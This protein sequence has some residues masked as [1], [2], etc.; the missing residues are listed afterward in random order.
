VPGDASSSARGQVGLD[1]LNFFLANA[2]TGFGAFIAVYLTSHKWTQ[3]EIGLV[4]SLGTAIAVIS[5]VPAG[6]LV[7]AL[8]KKR[9][10]AA[11]GILGIMAAAL[12]L[13]LLPAQLP[14]LLA[15]VLHAAGSA[16]LAPAIAAISLQLVGHNL[17]GERLGRNARYAAA[18]NGIA[19]A[20]MGTTGAYFSSRAVFWLTALLCI[21]ALAALTVIGR[22]PHARQQTTVHGFDRAAMRSLLFD[23]RLLLFAACVVLFQLADAAMLPLAATYVT[24][25]AGDF[26]N[27]IIAACIVLPQGVVALCAPWIG[28]MAAE[29]GRRPVLLLGWTVLPL[30]GLLLAVLPGPYLLLVAQ[31]VSGVSAA[32]IGVLLPLIAADLTR[33]T[34]HFNLCLGMLG[35]AVAVGA[36]LSTALAG[37][38]AGAVGSNATFLCLS[39]IGLAAAGLMWAAMPE[40]AQPRLAG[41]A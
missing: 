24:M 28:R 36:G 19:A 25:R 29:R 21:P 40:T 37:W 18:G 16:V 38:F 11:A 3:V 15:Q 30:R 7:D 13:A 12:L 20:I 23:R 26:A 22:G 39:A 8:P 1:L 6:A 27:L 4:L 35:L 10:A 32:V 9:A 41:S 14:V 5:Q 33:G 17:L 31:A 34:A 2:Q